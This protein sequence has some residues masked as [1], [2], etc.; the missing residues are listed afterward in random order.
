VNKSPLDGVR[1]VEMNDHEAIMRC[2][3]GDRE[4]FRHLVTRYEREAIGHARAILGD[5][6]EARDAAQEA[7]FAAYRSLDRFDEARRFYP[8]LYTILRNRCLKLLAARTSRRPESLDDLELVAPAPGLPAEEALALE[9]ALLDLGP[10]DREVLT[11]RHFDGLTYS[12]L[13]ALLEIPEGTV[14]S[15]LFNAR[16][17]LRERLEGATTTTRRRGNDERRDV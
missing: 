11:L 17:R 16:R 15:R 2:R 3:A 13:A 6:E 5:A 1:S 8:W 9:R 10:E 7:F 12:E 4:A 14:M